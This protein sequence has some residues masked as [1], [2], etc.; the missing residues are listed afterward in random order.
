MML[1][2]SLA[3]Q[4]FEGTITYKYKKTNASGNAGFFPQHLE[5]LYISFDKILFRSVDGFVKEHLNSDL[6]LDIGSGKRYEINHMERIT[7]DL[8][9]ETPDT[10]GF[11][12]KTVNEEPLVLGRKCAVNR[13]NKYSVFVQDT[14]TYTYWFAPSLALGNLPRFASLQGFHNTLILDGSFGVLPL[15]VLL[16]YRNGD[17]VLV[18]VVEVMEGKVNENVF[19]LPDYRVVK[20]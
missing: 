17:K 3:G 16:E 7:Y 9:P 14:I 13:F 8:S 5:R 4:T 11:K 1:S 18:E 19:A 12:I 20:K 6:L 10:T 2:A 15:K